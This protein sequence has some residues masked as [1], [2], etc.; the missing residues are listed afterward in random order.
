MT[1]EIDGVGYPWVR[2]NTEDFATNVALSLDP[3]TG[4]GS[5]LVKD[6]GRTVTLSEVRAVWYRKPEPTDLSHFDVDREAR[7][8]VEGEFNEVLSGI[9]SL[10]KEAFW[11]NN[12]L[13]IRLIHRKLY[14]L[15]VAQSVGLI[16]PATL[17][18]NVKD[19]VLKFAASIEG[20]LAIKSLSSLSVW[21]NRGTDTIQYGCFTR[22][23]GHEELLSVAEKIP[24]MPTTYQEYVEKMYEIRTTV[25]GTSFFSCRID[26][27]STEFGKDDFR[28]ATHAAAHHSAYNLPDDVERKLLQYMR[29]LG[30]NFGCFDII[31]STKGEYVFLECNPNGQWLWIEKFI[32]AG[33]GR[34]LARMLLEVCGYEIGE[35][36]NQLSIS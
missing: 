3:N 2:I 4:M 17:V 28:L 24:I 1:D 12:P 23:V 29:V 35:S 32:R 8:Y 15:N 19:D 21:N 36:S 16:T 7:D 30:M 33:I 5:M 10:L 13:A 25:V 11:I 27:Q 20:D 26:S 34:A 6:S 31:R 18:S 14:Q 9:Y 22:R